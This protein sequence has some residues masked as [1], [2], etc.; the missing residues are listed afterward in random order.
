MMY[1]VLV[2]YRRLSSKP[3]LIQ[4]AMMYL[5]LSQQL[6]HGPKKNLVLR[7][8][9]PSGTK[10]VAQHTLIVGGTPWPSNLSTKQSLRTKATG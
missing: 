8:Q 3:P 4:K 9:I 10:E 6:F 1:G 2:T 7:K 5:Y